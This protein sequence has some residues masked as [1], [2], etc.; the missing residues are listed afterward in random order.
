MSLKGPSTLFWIREGGQARALCTEGRDSVV[1][2]GAGH[3]FEGAKCIVLGPRG[4]GQAWALFTEGRSS[5]VKVG[6]WA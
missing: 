3:E 4:G 2:V 6:G 1:K 5:V